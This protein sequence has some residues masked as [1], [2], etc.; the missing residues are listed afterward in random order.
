MSVP[1]PLIVPGPALGR[2]VVPLFAGALGLSAFLLF[3]VQP[4]FAKMVLPVLGGTPAVWSVAMVFFQALLLAG[5]L[6]AHWTTRTFGLGAAAALHLALMAVAFLALPIAVASGWGQPPANGEALWLLGLFTVSVGLPFFAVAGNA[7]L[8]QAWFAR[9]GHGAAADPYFLYAASNAGSFAALLAYPFLL[10]PLLSLKD[11]SRLWSVGFVALAACVAACAATVARTGR[12]APPPAKAEAAPP[13]RTYLR[14][15]GL[16]FVPSGLLVATTAHLSTDIAA[17]PLLWV[18][19]LALYLLTFILAF[20]DRPFLDGRALLRLQIW[21]TALAIL[22]STAIGLLPLSLSVLLAVLFLGSL[23]CHRALYATRPPAGRLTDFYIC[24]S[25]GGV[26]GGLFCALVAPKI[27]STVLEY[28]LLLGLALFCHPRVL[29]AL[30][31]PGVRRSLGFFAAAGVAAWAA[32][33]FAPSSGMRLCVLGALAAA[34]MLTW[35][36]PAIA[37][38]ALVTAAFA[39]TLFATPPGTESLRSFFGVHKIGPSGDGRFLTLS[40]GTTIH[41][42]MR[43][44]NDDGSPA[45]GRPEPTTYYTFDGALGVGIR[46]VREARGGRLAG[47]GV[48]GLGAGSLACHAAAGERWTFFEIDPL[49]AKLARERF[50]FLG[51]CAPDAAIVLGDARLTLAGEP[52]GLSLL[53]LDAFSSDA[54]PTHLLTRE[55]IGLYLARLAPDGAVLMHISNRYLDLRGILAR[56]AAEHGLSLWTWTDA[57]GEPQDLRFRT[58]SIVAALA[59]DPA[60]LGAIASGGVWRRVEPDPARRPWTDD[61]SNVLAAAFDR[62]RR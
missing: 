56:T 53:V 51:A 7:P 16:A 31:R 48:V 42:A 25:L 33:T 49:V 29:A 13:V 62:Y 58:P 22:D 41:G 19:P 11:Q 61:F 26:L 17:A 27:F 4:M 20:R 52:G 14:W 60:H 39:A 36:R 10:E 24:L 3:A 50:R 45:T 59:R 46:A 28:P 34:A 1:S 2:L 15:I 8:L 57:D 12:T 47:V 37:V 5:Y 54:I 18:V 44:R 30:R 38:P 32:A 9:S 6:Y 35:R 40:H 21:T 23:A 55:A 43:V